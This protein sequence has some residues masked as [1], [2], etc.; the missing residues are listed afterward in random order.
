[1]KAWRRFTAVEYSRPT[2]L[3]TDIS[4]GLGITRAKARDLILGAGERVRNSLVLERAPL[5]WVGESVQT[6]NFAGLLLL[7]PGIEL[8]VAPKFLGDIPGWREDFFLL[9]TLTHHG[10]LLDAHGIH[11]SSRD[12]SDLATL[13]GRSLVEMYWRNQRRPLR[14]YRRHAVSDFALEGDFDA[15]D[16]LMPGED[17]FAQEVTSFTRTNPFNSVIAAAASRLAPVVPDSETRARLERVAHNLPRQ[18]VPS[19]PEARRMPSRARA[20]QPTYDLA[21]DILNGLGGAYDPA[22]AM[23]PGFIVRTWQVW[24]FLVMAS[25]RSAFGAANVRAQAG[26]ELGRR[27]TG[28]SDVSLQVFPDNIVAI[29]PRRL[30]VDAKYKG[31][32]E[33]DATA[34]SNADI[35]EALA[36]CRSTGINDVVLAYPRRVLGPGLTAQD[37]AGAFNEFSVVTIGAVVIRAVELGVC[38]IS[39]RD[40]LRR[41][42]AGLR[43]YV[44]SFTEDSSQV[45]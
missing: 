21:V 20:W 23:A 2:P 25:L 37:M 8:E 5:N 29:G 42:K 24:E 38:G 30:L 39:Q 33:R 16:L 40:G 7:A 1:M 45:H 28:T 26:H 32:V 13:I 31:N 15:T 22:N 3:I 10:R 19:R 17:G 43:D 12:T 44:G 41:F 18:V 9:A 36:F 14:T 27:K 11:A 35:Y 4:T 34:V 6:A